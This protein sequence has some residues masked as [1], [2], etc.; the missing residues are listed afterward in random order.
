MDKSQNYMAL[1]LEL[2]TDT[3][4]QTTKIIQVGIAIGNAD[5]PDDI[6]VKSWYINPEEPLSPH[7]QT[8]T[9]ITEVNV[10]QESTPIN[11]IADEIGELI[12]SKKVFIN[13]I[14]WGGGDA[15]ELKKLFEDNQIEFPYF[16]HRIIDV[17]TF[18][19]FIELANNRSL[20]GG[21]RSCMNK[22]KLDFIGKPH[23]ADVDAFNTLRFY[24]FLIERQRKL[25][26]MMQTIKSIK[27]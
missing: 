17:K 3:D 24:F 5:Q 15:D 23:R 1:D 16:G 20:A 21:L 18:F 26:S 7:I 14:Q 22:Y 4:G 10:Q 6:L 25:E 19:V 12:Q 27:Y 9:G 11:Q 2:N 13:P 8:L